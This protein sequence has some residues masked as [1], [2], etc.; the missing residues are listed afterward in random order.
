MGTSEKLAALSAQLDQLKKWVNSDAPKND[1]QRRDNER[2]EKSNK[3]A[4]ASNRD[5]EAN[6][7]QQADWNNRHRQEV[8]NAWKAMKEMYDELK[9]H[10]NP[11][12]HWQESQ[13]AQQLRQ[14]REVRELQEVQEVQGQQQPRWYPSQGAP[15]RLPRDRSSRMAVRR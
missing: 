13:Q 11:K 10:E 1:Q 15:E 2:Q 14:V 9:K 5:Q 6:N 8:N 7:K 12:L 4:R 3:D